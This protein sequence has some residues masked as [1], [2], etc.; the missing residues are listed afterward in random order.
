MI[1]ENLSETEVSEK[2]AEVI[3]KAKSDSQKNNFTI[4]KNQPYQLVAV[5][6]KAPL[7]IGWV[8]MGFKINNSLANTLHKL[9]NLEVTF[10]SQAGKSPWHS[11]AS[12]MSVGA[13]EQIVKY[14]TD[15]QAFNTPSNLELTIGDVAFN[16]VI[17]S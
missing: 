8:V 11:T 17:S 7:T 12:T 2:I 1:S 15:Q 16:V 9:S 13:T 4:F 5:P 3:Y 10:I 6:V 14:T